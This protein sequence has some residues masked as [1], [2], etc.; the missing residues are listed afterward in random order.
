MRVPLVLTTTL[1]TFLGTN[2]LGTKAVCE[3]LLPLMAA[4]SRT[5][6]VCST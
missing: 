6:N 2:L 3:A 4:G 5:V 1:A